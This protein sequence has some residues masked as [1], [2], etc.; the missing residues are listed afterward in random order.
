[1][2]RVTTLRHVFVQHI[3]ERLEDGVLYVAMEFGTVVHRCC[4]GC[5]MKV[6]TPL[7]PTDW[8]LIYDGDSVSLAPSVGNWSFPCRSHYWIRK[9]AVFWTIQWSDERIEAG[10]RHDRIAK[11]RHFGE[12]ERTP[13][14]DTPYRPAPT[15][16]PEGTPES[17]AE[18]RLICEPSAPPAKEVACSR[19][20]SKKRGRRR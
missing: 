16:I 12:T 1:M 14:S 10:R 6:V 20:K 8:T 2:T 7:S 5:G 9:N 18:G 17:P 11:R 13:T 4:C 19:P 15:V 3:P